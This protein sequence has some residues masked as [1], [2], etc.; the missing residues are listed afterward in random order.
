MESDTAFKVRGT[1]A[2]GFAAPAEEELSDVISLDDF[3]IGNKEASYM[4]KVK[5]DSMIDAGIHEG[6]LV[7]VERGGEPRN[8]DIVIA[9]IDGGWTMKYLRQRS[10]HRFLEPANK[11]YQ[12]IYP[13]ND[14]KI[15]A[16][17]RA[18]V[19]KY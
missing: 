14:M 16:V 11:K 1:V 10:G 19:R 13:E 6:D 9:E 2:A 8:G 7:I 5:G 3:L 4:L 18:V 17:V 15:A 12:S